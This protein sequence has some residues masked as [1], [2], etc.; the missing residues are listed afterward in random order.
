MTQTSARP[1]VDFDHHSAAY[2]EDW[3]RI[4]ASLRQQCPVAYTENYDGYWVVS[5]YEHV[6][7][8]ARDDETYASGHDM[9]GDGNGYG[10]I[11]IPPAPFKSTPIESDG[12][13]FYS[14]RKVLTP[15][16]SPNASAAWEPYVR[17]SAA[18]HLDAVI[19]RGEMDVVYDYAAPVPAKV[20]MRLLGL[21]E[22]SWKRYA[23]PFHELMSPPDS[24]RYNGAVTAMADFMGDLYEE[25]V[26]HRG[27]LRDDLISH[28]LRAE[29]GGEPI[30]DQMLLEIVFLVIAGGVDTTTSAFALACE[31]LSAH[32]EQRKLLREE[33]KRIPQ[34]IEEFLRYFSPV[35]TMARTATRDHELGGCPIKSDDRI[36][37][38]WVAANH[39]PEQFEAPEEVRLDRAPNR[40]TAFGLGAHRCLGSSLGR[41]QLKVLFEEFLRR[42]PDFRTIPEKTERYGSIGLTN[43]LLTLP[44]TFTPGPRTGVRA[45][46]V[47]VPSVGARRF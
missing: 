26:E 12:E 39:D 18:E 25:I 46:D 13:E 15:I 6:G 47:E 38:P 17:A 43:G 37:V 19:E 20:T 32:P 28:L 4:Y 21:P 11:S 22:E 2:T 10:G 24:E 41:M 42:V 31:W 7:E 3:R 44:A 30:G 35:Q 16:F 5:S 8:V 14:V 23:L 36:L 34:A 45:G 1:M 33:P 27:N 40:H 29:I 9:T